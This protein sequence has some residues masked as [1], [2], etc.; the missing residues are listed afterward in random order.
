MLESID[1]L[2]RVL[3]S[4]TTESCSYFTAIS[5]QLFVQSPIID[6]CQLERTSTFDGIDSEKLWG[7][8]YKKHWVRFCPDYPVASR[9]HDK[10]RELRSVLTL[11]PREVLYSYYNNHILSRPHPDRMICTCIGLH[12]PRPLRIAGREGLISQRPRPPTAQLRSYLN[13]PGILACI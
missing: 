4:C 5:L 13:Q 8:L 2:L 6:I 10:N 3:L 1:Q 7:E 12:R 9:V 11:Q